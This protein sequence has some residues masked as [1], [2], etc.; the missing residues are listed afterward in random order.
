MSTRRHRIKTEQLLVVK[1]V[2]LGYRIAKGSVFEKAI[3]LIDSSLSR[4]P[5]NPEV[6]AFYLM[7]RS[8]AYRF[9]QSKRHLEDRQKIKALFEKSNLQG[10]F[11]LFSE[12]VEKTTSRHRISGGGALSS[13]DK[14]QASLG[15]DTWVD[16]DTGYEWVIAQN[17]DVESIMKLAG[18]ERH[19]M[20]DAD[21]SFLFDT[22]LKR[23]IEKHFGPSLTTKGSQK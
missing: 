21:R 4:Q 19:S 12:I 14:R 6:E 11:E 13:L 9:R 2:T 1:A 17:D 23:M 7:V 15:S 20:S 18:V 3:G 10:V 22:T 5:V 8:E 16:P